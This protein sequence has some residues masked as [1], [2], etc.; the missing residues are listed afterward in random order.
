MSVRTPREPERSARAR[1]ARNA[2][3]V[4]AKATNA[5]HSRAST[6]LAA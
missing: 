2:N 4:A 1:P 5:I 3:G 6:W